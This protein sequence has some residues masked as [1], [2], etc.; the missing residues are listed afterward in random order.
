MPL[1]TPAPEPDDHAE[2]AAAIARADELLRRGNVAGAR[3]WLS[4]PAD[5]DAEAMFRLAETYDP[6]MLRLWGVVGLPGDTEKAREY[7]ARAERAGYGPARDR[8]NALGH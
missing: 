1:P 6:R 7:Y 8:L 2:D 5:R 4:G 3:L